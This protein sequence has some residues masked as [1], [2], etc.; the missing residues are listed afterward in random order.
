VPL[1]SP[2]TNKLAQNRGHAPFIVMD[3]HLSSGDPSNNLMSSRLSIAT[4][5]AHVL[6][7]GVITS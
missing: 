6:L 5:P 2:A 1:F 4:P 7:R 3:R